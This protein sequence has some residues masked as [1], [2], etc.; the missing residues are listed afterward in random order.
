[1]A[2]K[3]NSKAV[4]SIL[5]DE[6]ESVTPGTEREIDYIG[7]S[8][9]NP[10]LFLII[11]GHIIAEH[12]SHYPGNA[13][14]GQWE[15]PPYDYVDKWSFEGEIAIKDEYCNIIETIDYKEVMAKAGHKEFI[16]YLKTN[17]KL[18]S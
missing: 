10:D 18:A 6:A 16:H 9:E 14:D 13:I 8:P 17:Q 11:S 2:H 3:T 5:L 7:K 12:T 1:M 4:I 15:T